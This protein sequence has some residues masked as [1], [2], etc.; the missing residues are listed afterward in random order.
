MF[1]ELERQGHQ[2]FYLN[3]RI[4]IF[5]GGKGKQT[6][7]YARDLTNDIVIYDFHS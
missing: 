3:D 1:S 7:M 2:A 5:G 4:Y 6:G